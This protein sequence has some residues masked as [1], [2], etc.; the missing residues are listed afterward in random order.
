MNLLYV[1]LAAG[2]ALSNSTAETVRGLRDCIRVTLGGPELM[3][4]F[5]DVLADE[6]GRA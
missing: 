5:A 4:P 3:A 2:T 6:L 1:L